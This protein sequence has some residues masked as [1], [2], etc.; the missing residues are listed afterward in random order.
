[1]GMFQIVAAVSGAL[2]GP[3]AEL[4]L[5]SPIGSKEKLL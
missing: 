4:S 1:M 2:G 3:N 5:Y